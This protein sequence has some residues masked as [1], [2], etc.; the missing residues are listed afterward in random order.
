MMMSNLLVEEATEQCVMTW[1]VPREGTIRLSDQVEQVR[2]Q[3]IAE[4]LNDKYEGK[5]MALN[6]RVV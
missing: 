2:E 4:P 3:I 6:G 1:M 5:S